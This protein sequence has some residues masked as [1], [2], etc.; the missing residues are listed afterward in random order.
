MAAMKF[1]DHRVWRGLLAFG[2]ATSQTPLLTRGLPP[3]SHDTGGSP[4]VSKGVSTWVRELVKVIS[5]ALLCFVSVS[6]Q[7][8]R[9]RH[10]QLRAALD[11]GDTATAWTNLLNLRSNTAPPVFAANNYD[12]LAGRL[13]LQRGDTASAAANFEA[14]A[15]R[16]SPLAVYALWHLAEIARCAGNL[17]QERAA[18]RQLIA[19]APANRLRPAATMRLARSFY[20]S[21][22][23]PSVVS[24]LK[25]VAGDG[26]TAAARPA[27]VLLAQALLASQQTDEARAAFSLLV[28]NLPNPAQP[29][30]YALAAARA[31]D[32][33]DGSPPDAANAPQLAEA[34]HLRRAQV[35]QF[36][37][38]F[39]GA[40]RHWL[41][42]ANNFPQSAARANALFQIGRGLGQ[43]GKFA[44]S[45]AAY[46]RVLDEY[47]GRDEARDALLFQASALVRLGKTDEA[48]AAYEKYINAYPDADNI[49]RPYVNIIDALR[50]AGR[51][52]EALRWAA[53]G[54]TDL[55][56][57]IGAALALFS[58]AKIHLSQNNWPAVVTDCDALLTLND[59]GGARYA[60]GATRA[61]VSFLRAFAL[62]QQGLT[63]DAVTAYLAIPDGRNE[64]YGWRATLR[65]RALAANEK[66]RRELAS[67]AENLSAA[68]A[69]A[70]DAK[71]FEDGRRAAQDAL[72]L[73]D[74]A[75][76]RA[77]LLDLARRAYAGLPVYSRVTKPNLLPA[78]RAEPVNEPAPSNVAD[79]LLFLGL[80]DEGAPELAAA[81]F[82]PNSPVVTPQTVIALQTQPLSDAAFTQATLFHRAQEENRALALVEPFWRT[83]PADYLVE[84]APREMAELLYPAPYREALL[85]HSATRQLDPRF[86]LSIARQESRFR[87]DAKSVAAARGMMQFIAAT[88]ASIAGQLK[89]NQ[90]GQDDLYDPHTAIL[91]GAQ[92]LSNL[93]KQFPGQ[94]QAVAAS[95]NGGE[96][97]MARW[98]KRSRSNDPDRYVPEI[99][100]AQSKDYVLRV[101]ANLRVYQTLYD[102]KLAPPAP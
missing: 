88:A 87:A 48:V 71:Y 7:T 46:Q 39:A 34:E 76:L 43:E 63:N 36:N 32:A 73:T 57:K 4:R 8:L 56:G 15:A 52:A 9:E 79:E 51:D 50:D 97:N 42:L 68:A 27:L 83:V 40:R 28:M 60:G 74:D 94:P 2:L 67:R 58:Q 6:A 30:D 20:E 31:L 16:N 13:A 86:L 53:R 64:Y 11:K 84:L 70:I 19:N 49:E 77:S 69:K 38:D 24:T 10:E 93:F 45:V 25:P 1:K 61:E 101:M 14:V 90:F 78:G 59:L 89:L 35:Y 75:R 81:G 3:A 18:L 5:F 37:R 80:Y 85:L 29:D 95:Y 66:T 100:F 44:E 99:G 65:L 98:L 22:D 55:K 96:E 23:F 41:A 12:Y 92:Y 17:P 54:Q 102:E 26:K 21:G 62:E 47:K 91:F 82:N 33:L 72:R